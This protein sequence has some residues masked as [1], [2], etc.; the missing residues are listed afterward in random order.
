MKSTVLFLCMY[1]SI[2]SQM[3]E[4]L[5]AARYGER[6]EAYSAGVSPAGIDPRA[7]AAMAEAGIDISGQRSEAV[8]MYSDRHF[9]YLV[10]LDRTAA[11]RCYS[12]PEADKILYADIAVPSDLRLLRETLDLWITRNFD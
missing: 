11:E 5:L 9:S 8:G 2:R 10:I 4:G 7:V 6:Y 12:L 1:N 3:A